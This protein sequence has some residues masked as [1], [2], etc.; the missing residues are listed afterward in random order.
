[1]PPALAAFQKGVPE[2]KVLLHD[3]SSDEIVDG[4]RTGRLQLAITAWPTEDYHPDVEFESLKT[5]PVCAV[6][7]ATHPLARL[8][9][10][11]L[12]KIAAEP[13]VTLNRKSYP[14]AHAMLDKLFRSLDVKPRI[15]LECDSG[16]SVITAIESGRGIALFSPVLKLVA[17]NRLRYR[18]V[19]GIT[20]VVPVGIVRARN[21]DVT[22]AG[23]KFCAILRKVAKKMG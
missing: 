10:I 1:L 21:G 6:L 15:A 3:M 14:D 2:V 8:K 19:T 23:E 13:I 17:G 18:P 7:S 4:L 11:P 5:Y 22:P 16:S 12:E 20:D 9:T